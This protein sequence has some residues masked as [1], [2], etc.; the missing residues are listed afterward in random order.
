MALLGSQ[1]H[2]NEHLELLYLSQTLLRESLEFLKIP[3]VQE[4]EGGGL[5]P[6]KRDVSPFWGSID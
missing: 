1:D 4:G 2:L 3:G 6:V 5:D